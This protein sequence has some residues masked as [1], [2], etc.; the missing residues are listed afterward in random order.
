MA[1]LIDSCTGTISEGYILYSGGTTAVGQAIDRGVFPPSFGTIYSLDSV[2]FSLYA[3]TGTTGN[4]YA[5]VYV[6]SGVFGDNM[7]PTGSPIATSD[8]VDVSTLTFNYQEVSFQFSG[9][10]KIV[11]DDDFY[12]VITCEYSGGSFS[13]HVGVGNLG[14]LHDGN[15]SFKPST[16][17]YSSEEDLYFKL[18]GNLIG[19]T[20]GE[21][22]PLPAFKN[23]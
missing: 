9:E 5:K 12:L 18:Y 2:V 22:Y 13:N 10:N 6:G 15:L 14:N 11:M 19:P 1:V 8:P 23:G 4:A 16:W 21:K 17:D 20:V 3:E 7:I